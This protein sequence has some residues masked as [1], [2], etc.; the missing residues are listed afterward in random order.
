[1]IKTFKYRIY[2]KKSQRS[3]LQGSL[4]ACRWVYNTT[5]EVRRDTWEN[6]GKSLSLYDTHNFLKPWKEEEPWLAEQAFSQSLQN[7]QARVDLAFNAFFRRVKAGDK[8]GYPRFRGVDR[9][10]SFTFTQKGFKLIDDKYLRISK[11]GIVRIKLHRPID[12]KI[13]TLTIGRNRLGYWYASFN[14]EVEPKRLQLTDKCVGIDLGLMTFA[15]MSDGSKI[16]RQ[17]WFKQ[18]EKDLTKMQRKISA[19]QKGSKKRKHMIRSLNHIYQRIFYRRSDFSHKESRKLVNKY[20]IIVF[21]DLDIADMQSGNW[22]TIN[23]SIADVAWSQFVRH[24]VAKAEEAGRT[25]VLVDPKNTSQMCSGCGQIAKKDLHVR[26]HNC[27]HCGLKIDRDF[28]ASINILRRGL[29]SL[30]ES[31]KSSPLWR[32]AQSQHECSG[33][34]KVN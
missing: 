4:D 32:G 29:A 21:E 27:P 23:R 24:T 22:K 26:I 5:L 1:M 14:V 6:D 20:Q 17:R 7:A 28:N 31:Q 9:Y 10:D 8:P 19:L 18:D 3:A 15:T 34:L 30:G 2:P 13:K 11:V 16:E 33:I 12:G 25:V